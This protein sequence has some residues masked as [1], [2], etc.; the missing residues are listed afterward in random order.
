MGA[1]LQV[2]VM[3]Q[4]RLTSGGPGRAS[5][6]PP[7]PVNFHAAGGLQRLFDATR[8]FTE[9]P[10]AAEHS[11]YMLARLA[12]LN[13][14]NLLRFDELVLLANELAEAVTVARR[15]MDHNAPRVY[16]GPCGAIVEDVECFEELWAAEHDVQ[17]H[18][19]VCGTTWD[20]AARRRSALE[21]IAG[22]VETAEQ[23]SRA[24]TSF[25]VQ[26]TRDDIRY[27][28]K[29]GLITRCVDE[30]GRATYRVGQVVDAWHTMQ[31]RGRGR[32]KPAGA[33]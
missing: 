29:K 25:Q 9:A 19:R 3:R 2:M 4:D 8:A 31:E 15:M 7:L 10:P 12:V 27:W 21:A 26:V 17:I 33:P 23:I 6:A 32:K 22:Q 24:L 30:H 5:T 28:W 11:L 20:I 18:C 13:L 14:P 1:D 16:T